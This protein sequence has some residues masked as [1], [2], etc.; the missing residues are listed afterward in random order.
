MNAPINDGGP[1][2]ARSGFDVDTE[3]RA[4]F[5]TSP[6]EGMTLRDYFAAQSLIGLLA[7]GSVPM[8]Y[9]HGHKDGPITAARRAYQFADAMLAA[10]SEGGAT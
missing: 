7:C 1:A 3:R 9:T 10:R 2:F 4:K 5:A 8:P 6:Q